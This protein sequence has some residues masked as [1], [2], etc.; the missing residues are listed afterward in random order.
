MSRT[1]D[2]RAEGLRFQCTQ[3]GKCCGGAPGTVLV[4]SE[5]LDALA[6]AQ[7]LSLEQFREMY[8]RRLPSGSLS[9]REKSNHD[10][11][12]YEADRG[13]TVYEQRPQQCRTWPFWRG[14]I[15]SREHWASAAEECPGIGQGEAYSASHIQE[16][17][18]K[19][20]TSGFIP[21]LKPK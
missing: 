17:A 16:L 21:K 10:C 5:E 13:C 1:S 7:E 15:A 19:D 11:V 20:G 12:F 9:L 18:A 4:H 14:N 3:C 6:R 8:T 2:W